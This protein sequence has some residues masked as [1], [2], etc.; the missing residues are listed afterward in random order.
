MFVKKSKIQRLLDSLSRAALLTL[1][2]LAH[3][4]Y[5][6]DAP[7]QV[8]LQGFVAPQDE[9]LDVVLRVPMDALG[10]ID[11][12]E[13]GPGYLHFRD[14]EIAL[15]DAV[16]V[17]VIDGL[18]FYEGNQLL[19]KPSVVNRRVSLPSDRSF[20]DLPTA[21][22]HFSAPTLDDNTDLIW[23]QGFLDVH[24][25][26]T[27]ASANSRFYLNSSLGNL[28][29]TTT[30]VLKIILPSGTE[31]AFNFE[32]NPG[33]IELDP[34]LWQAFKRFVILGF[35]HILTGYDHLLFLFCL[36]I[37]VRRVRELLI[38]VTAFTLAHSITLISASLGLL[39]NTLWFTPLVE[40]LIALSVLYMACENIIG[41]KLQ[42]RWQLTFAF[43][44]IHGFGFSF[45]LTDSLQFAGGHLISSLLAF[46]VGVE[47]GQLLVLVLAVPLLFLFFKWA[48]LKTGTL[49]LS[50]FAAHSAWHWSTER[51]EALLQ[52]RLG[53]VE[54]N[55]Q[56]FADLMGWLMLAV[57]AAAGLWLLGLCE[58]RFAPATQENNT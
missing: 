36:L 32:G 9:R 49:L 37:P 43:G 54:I 26:Y 23:Q 44:L 39:P 8:T 24:L 38:P 13:R 46:N 7:L 56:F 31:R 55:A 28:G 30:T 15:N 1:A 57:V 40:T 41:A 17:Y 20:I 14:A 45:L 6:H 53:S 25:R 52:Y 42:R 4:S 12:P 33:L 27:I 22:D 10:E 2:L 34:S 5:A 58:K 16:S 35:E 48:P 47:L 11:F 21:L 18:Q 19:E 3:F 51:V 50:A 29:E